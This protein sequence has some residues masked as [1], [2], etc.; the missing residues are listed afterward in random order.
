[1]PTGGITLN[2]AESYLS[3]SNVRAVGGT[4]LTPPDAVI[5][6]RWDTITQIA[7]KASQLGA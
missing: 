7:L 5:D 1:V 2:N 6:K 3:L 4:W